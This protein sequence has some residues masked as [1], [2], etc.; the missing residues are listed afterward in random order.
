MQE[1]ITSLIEMFAGV[2]NPSN[3]ALSPDGST[4][5]FVQQVNDV[6]QIFVMSLDTRDWHRRITQTL[7]DCD[8][9]RWSP[10]GKQIVFM[11]G[12]ALWVMEA[13]GAHARKLIEHPAKN[14]DPRW[15][16]DGSRIAFYSRRRGW[17]HIW[18]IR[19]DGTDLKQITRGD[20]DAD[21]LRW[22]PN[23]E[24]LVYCSTREDDLL[25]RGIYFVPSEGGAEIMATPRGCWNG[26]PQISPDGK[27]LA[28]LSDADGWFNI[29]LF[30]LHARTTRQLTRGECEI[31]GP[32]F[33]D[34]AS[35]GGPVFSRDGA[36][37]AYIKHRDA[38]FDVWVIDA[39]AFGKN[40][41]RVST[42]DG[43]YRI[44]GWKDAQTLVVTFDSLSFPPD[45]YLLSLDGNAQQITNSRLPEM[46]NPIAPEWI[47]YKSRDGL[48]IHAGLF[49]PKSS[50]EKFP[51]VVFLHGGPNFQFAQFY[52]PLPQILAQSG[53]V[54]FAPNFRGSTGFGTEFRRA[55]FREWG[56]A[57]AFDAIDGTRWLAQQN[58][59]DPARI[60][61]I[62]PSYGGYLTL[63]ALTLA[64]ELFCA[65]VDLYGD[66]EIA[67]SYRHGERDGR[68]DLKRQMG[69]PEE[70]SE[71]YK[72]GSPLYLAS[73]IQA[74]L[75]ILHG[76]DDLLVVPLMSEKMIEALKIEGKYFESHFY[77]DE[78]HGFS[79]PQNRR[80]AVFCDEAISKFQEQKSLKYNRGLGIASQRTLAMTEE[81]SAKTNYHRR[82]SRYRVEQTRN[83]P[84]FFGK[85]ARK[86]RARRRAARARRRERDCWIRRN[87]ASERARYFRDAIRFT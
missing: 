13:N 60:A 75:L 37:I 2:T 80:G 8:T 71:G 5:A 16:P 81:H 10:D 40:E 12:D 58:F 70:N 35:T 63:C 23:S 24:W 28:Y 69:T 59:V 74:P 9:P 36:R 65:G 4:I 11:R 18:T 76:K 39:D 82:T 77:D 78:G 17:N 6:S 43:N 86:T 73:R 62:G 52:Y 87:R 84:R 3:Y 48:D 50:A 83:G 44:V 25:T 33:Y 45:L 38:K 67:E 64:P 72:R 85:R 68:L 47:S 79:S 56:H 55:N 49:R 54:V 26:A 21:D 42:L 32:F 61:V 57:D 1:R 66:S 51:A 27:T 34:V 53:Y 31:G 14:S 46:E 22:T 41:R 7:D 20:F 30:D 15:S 19:A 29:Y